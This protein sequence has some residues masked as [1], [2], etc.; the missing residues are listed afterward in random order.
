MTF[1]RLILAL[2]I[3]PMVTLLAATEIRSAGKEDL[4]I[5]DFYSNP[6]SSDTS[7]ASSRRSDQTARQIDNLLDGKNLPIPCA[8]SLLQELRRHR[9][10]L[11]DATRDA[12]RSLSQR[13]SLPR[14]GNRPTR[15]GRYRIHFTSELSSPD[16][17]AASDRD[18]NGVPDL[19]DQV[20]EA[21]ERSESEIVQRLGWPAPA[22]GP[23]GD[24]YDIY[25][26]SL[27]AGRQGLTVPDRDIP[28]TPQDDAFSHILLDSHL[29]G[30]AVLSAVS[31]QISHA[32][33]LGLSTRSPAWWTEATAAWLEVQVTGNPAPQ[34]EALAAR[35]ERLDASLSTDSLLLSLGDLLWAS[36]LAE[37][38][39]GKG[40]EIRQIWL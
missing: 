22:S 3:L 23:R 5:S 29:E 8:S 33:L 26:V 15:D 24:R 36:Y 1:R 10:G 35:L 39:E 20:E 11:G 6:S 4:R 37:Q 21:L 32:S 9:E 17:I 38:R 7:H 34:R 19:V 27:G 40:E 30:D 14:D 12:L 2:L 13:P 28:S 16:A 31:H 25:L 18:F